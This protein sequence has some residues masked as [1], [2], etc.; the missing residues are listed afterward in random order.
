MHNLHSCYSQDVPPG[1]T[2]GHSIQ[3]SEGTSDRFRRRLDVIHVSDSSKGHLSTAF[4]SYLCRSDHKCVVV[5]CAPPVFHT[6]HPRFRCLDVFLSNQE[7]TQQVT[8]QLEDLARSPVERWESAHF[9]LRTNA[10]QFSREHKQVDDPT[11]YYSC[12]SIPLS[13]MSLHKA[14][15]SWSL[16]VFLLQHML[17]LILSSLHYMS[18]IRQIRWATSF[19]L[20]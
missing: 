14:G 18:V 7:T 12:C 13:S 17:K 20:S 4:T 19:S 11:R 6:Q 3:D 10:I 9:I 16:K 8:G 15:S 5:A 1:Y 2:Y